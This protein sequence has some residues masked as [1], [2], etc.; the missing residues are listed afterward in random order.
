M[1]TELEATLKIVQILNEHLPNHVDARTEYPPEDYE[2]PV[3]E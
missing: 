1:R 3:D 2:T